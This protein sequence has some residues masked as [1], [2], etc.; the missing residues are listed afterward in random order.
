MTRPIE[1][2]EKHWIRISAQLW[3]KL[4]YWKSLKPSEFLV[5]LMKKGVSSIRLV[6]LLRML[7]DS[8]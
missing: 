1:L 5:P 3:G 7:S 4:S 8:M 2:K 6:L